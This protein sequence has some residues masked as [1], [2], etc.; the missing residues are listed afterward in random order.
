MTT[1]NITNPYIDELDFEPSAFFRSAMKHVADANAMSDQ[2][3]LEAMLAWKSF[4]DNSYE[5]HECDDLALVKDGCYLSRNGYKLGISRRY[6]NYR[7]VK[8]KPRNY[9]AKRAVYAG[10]TAT[11]EHYRLAAVWYE[12]TE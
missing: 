3:I 9:I 8:L 2:H 7:E 5:L 1:Y 11:Q 4:K 6:P 12:E 10:Y